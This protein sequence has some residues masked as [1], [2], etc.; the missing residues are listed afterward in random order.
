MKRNRILFLLLL[1]AFSH[2]S[3][4]Q[5]DYVI[6]YEYTD[7]IGYSSSS[8]LII[9][10]NKESIFKVFDERESGGGTNPD[11]QEMFYVVNDE[12]ST[13]MYSNNSE[14]YTRIPYKRG[15]FIYKYPSNHHEWTLTGE[16]KKINNYQC[17]KAVM[18]LH[19]RTY[20]VWFT[21]EIPVN[22]G[23]LKLNGLPGL[24]VEGK[25]D[26]GYFSFSLLNVK[27]S[28]DKEFFNFYKGFF[29]KT[30]KVYSYNDYKSTLTNYMTNL[31]RKQ[32]TM[33]AEMEVTISFDED[34]HFFTQYL[35]DIPENLIEELQKI[36]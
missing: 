12:L 35:I 1:I 23:P 29:Q 7:R 19:E 20:C 22:F 26:K 11:T 16:S 17:Q 21:T 14:I 5:E 13:F 28:W 18:K 15:R 9:H 8:K 33:A 24:I 34:Q 31:K 32:V 27:K 3:F 2:K 6:E 30:K 25:D 4:S 36:N 10:N